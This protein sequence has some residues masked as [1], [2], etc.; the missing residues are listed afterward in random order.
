M[1]QKGIYNFFVVAY[2]ARFSFFYMSNDMDLGVETELKGGKVN[3]VFCIW[4]SL[5]ASL[6]DSRSL[7]RLDK[8]EPQQ[9]FA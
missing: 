6:T 3:K 7:L 4:I 9:V 8:M 1:F 5:V 2:S